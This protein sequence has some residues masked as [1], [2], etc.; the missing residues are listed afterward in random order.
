MFDPG[1]CPLQRATKGLAV[2]IAVPD[3]IERWLL[4]F[5]NA[6]HSM[7]NL[8]EHD[9]VIFGLRCRLL[10]SAEVHGWMVLWKILS[11]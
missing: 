8:M 1:R 3:S 10:K 7:A 6:A 11:H 5:V 9:S 2:F 4:M